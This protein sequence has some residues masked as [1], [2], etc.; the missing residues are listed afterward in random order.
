[1]KRQVWRFLDDKV[2][3]AFSF[4][5]LMRSEVSRDYIKGFR[6][7]RKLVKG[8]RLAQFENRGCFANENCNQWWIA[9]D[10]FC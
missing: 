9:P 4:Y 8:V 1:M 5:R 6:L 3:V 10:S 2:K 7:G